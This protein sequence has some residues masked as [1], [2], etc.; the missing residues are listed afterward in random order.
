MRHQKWV[1]VCVC[2][3]TS[4][5]LPVFSVCAQEVSDPDPGRFARSFKAFAQQDVDQPFDTGGIVF[6]GSSSIRML[7]IA[8]VFP[9]VKAL[10]RGFGGA[11]ISDVNHYLERA[12]LQYEPSTVVFFCG[13][14]DLWSGKS[15]TQVK[16]DF[17]G[18]TKRLFVRV[19]QAE[20]IVL[21]LRPSPSRISRIDNQRALNALFK[22]QARKDGRVTYLDG[23]WSRFLDDQ[24]RC[25]THLYAS[26]RLHMNDAGYA[27]WGEIIRPLLNPVFLVGGDISTL[28]KIEQLG[29]VFQDQNQPGDCIKILRGQG[30][31]CFR[32]RLFV[33]PTKR[34]AVVQDL[35]YTL[36]LAKRIKASG[37]QLLLDFHYSDTWADPGKQHKPAAWADLD[38]QALVEQVRTYTR[39]VIAAYKREGVLPDMVQVGNEI[40]PGFLWPDG[41][42]YRDNDPNE[43]WAEFTTLLKAGIAGVKEALDK[44]DLVRI[45]IHIDCG[46]RQQRSQYFFDH[47]RQYN[48][49][50]DM[51]GQSYYPWWH[52]TIEDVRTTLKQT[53]LAYDKDIV[54]V[55]TA[56]P[57]TGE[58][59]W[60]AKDNMAWPVTQQGQAAFLAELTEAVQQTPNHR[61]LGVIYWYPEAIEVDGMN[62]WNGGATAVFDRQGNVLPGARAMA[63]VN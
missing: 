49:E 20:L 61:G 3:C 54:L 23:S 15:P 10:N 42:I 45:M 44:D 22:A 17:E 63:P 30:W 14:N 46:A 32:L 12:V 33:N 1:V 59:W 58:Q 5:L 41:K 2:L 26:D 40:T 35:A 51:I 36:A 16:A 18:F 37:G 50:F 27:I 25:L 47:L 53:A 11:H 31:N 9:G 4:V 48:V 60:A 24:G 56:Y 21:A 39:D 55:E 13:G 43:H 34:N 28:T 57:W 62:I 52:G 7:D 8:S 29:G 38:F 19:P 6:V